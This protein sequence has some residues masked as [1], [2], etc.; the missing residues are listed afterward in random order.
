MGEVVARQ[1]PTTPAAISLRAAAGDAVDLALEDL[2]TSQ[3]RLGWSFKSPP[4]RPIKVGPAGCALAGDEPTDERSWDPKR[5]T[6]FSGY[7][8]TFEAQLEC[9]MPVDASEQ[10]AEARRAI[11]RGAVPAIATELYN[12]AKARAQIA[13]GNSAYGGNR[14][15]T[16]SDDPV[17]PLTV[18]A[19]EPT[20][21]PGAI[22]RL[23]S[24]LA[25]CSDV[26]RGVIHVPPAL[27]S[28]MAKEGLLLPPT[29]AG[30][31]RYSPA[32]HIVVSECGYTGD[33]PGTAAAGPHDPGVGVMWIYATGPLVIRYSVDSPVGT[34]AAAAALIA[35]TNDLVTVVGGS[36]MAAW[37]CCHAAAAV[38]VSAYGLVETGS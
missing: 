36:A 35:E 23:E 9:S 33:A 4:C 21:L 34:L 1:L 7:P 16:R 38:D 24:Y 2:G 8:F 25:C 37:G 27:V 13:G 31:T 17:S 29:T 14:W 30:G 12:G 6:L 28:P 10:L 11:D 18:V 26:G 22:G 15:I 5:P 3:W 20:E 32:G 19:N